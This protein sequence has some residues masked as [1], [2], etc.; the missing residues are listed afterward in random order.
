MGWLVSHVS[1]TVIYSQQDWTWT[2]S[3]FF[4]LFFLHLVFLLL[5]NEF[6]LHGQPLATDK[7]ATGTGLQDAVDSHK[8]AAVAGIRYL[9]HAP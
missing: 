7:Q 1:L 3:S 8:P 5:P 2:R 9:V 4:F 6:C